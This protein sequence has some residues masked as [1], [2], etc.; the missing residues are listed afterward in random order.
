MII[1]QTKERLK[2]F[3]EVH[4]WPIAKDLDF[5]NWLDNFETE[6]DR[7]LAAQILRF[8]VYIPEDVVNQLVQTV[9]GR[10][11]YF[12][13]ENDPTWN[14][15]SFKDSCW[16][17]FVQGEDKN[18]VTDSGYIFTRKLRDELDIP[19]ER[20][21]KYEELF[22]KLEQNDV[23]PQN[24][25]LVDDFVGTGAQTDSAWNVHKFGNRKLTLSDHVKLS[26]HRIVYAPLVVNE[27]G[28]SRI[29]RTCQDLH[30]E[31]IYRLTEDYSL[32]NENGLCW[33]GDL[34]KFNKFINLLHRVATKEGIPQKKG[35]HVNDM[36]GFGR[37]GLALAFNHG[38]P[39]ACPAFFYWD[40][41][42]WRPLKKRPYHR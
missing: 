36:L 8:F 26:H 37:Q 10:C 41:P 13:A 20:I 34:D 4:L 31:Y 29:T 11:G 17:S 16:Y 27:I 40:T 14:H 15:N 6:E 1:E 28:L 23:T 32:L 7:K 39:D 35:F 24:V 5:E 25:I 33:N 42:T 2:F 12:F 21:L 22:I 3:R 19:I 9:V 30:L 18:D 38:I